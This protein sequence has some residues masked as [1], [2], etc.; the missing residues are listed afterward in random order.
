[1]SCR[2]FCWRDFYY[3]E[4]VFVI[5]QIEGKLV[6]MADKKDEMKN[7]LKVILR[8]SI[9]GIIVNVLIGVFKAIVGI[10][11]NSIAITLDAVNN[12]TDA[13][14]GVITIISTSFSV[15]PANKKHPFGYG[16]MEYLGTLL[17]SVI[18]LY[19]GITALVESVKGIFHHEV[20][21]YSV[22]S[23]V[24]IVFAVVMKSVLAIYYSRVGKKIKSDSLVATAKEAIGDIAISISTIVAVIIFF[25]TGLSIEAWLGAIIALFII[26]TG[27]ELIHETV[28]KILGN[29]A[30]ASLVRDIKAAI[31]EYDQ[32]EGAYDLV[33]NNY[34]PDSYLATVHI[35]V[36]DTMPIT[37]FD[38]LSR[39]IRDDIATRFGVFITSVGVYSINTMN[40]DAINIRE[41]VRSLVL[42]INHVKQMH[43]FYVDD[44][45][46]RFDVVISFD[47][48][49]RMAVYNQVVELLQ[50]KYPSYTINI[51]MD[52][53]YNEI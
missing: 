1:M 21:K 10:V 28:G 11:S 37:E 43:G 2:L 19:A 47:A 6:V 50:D 36:K 17:I 31:I 30:D 53:D 39:T 12:L 26:K 29:G 24:I 8:T 23:I 5:H 42:D 7:R 52:M 46:M 27:G 33:L 32:V 13:G 14:S 51:G 22:V 35:E 25:V 4:S 3:N 34:G 20:A 38:S 9:I 41:D 18:I 44:N 15:K 16:R 49:D 40:T 45:N 48:A